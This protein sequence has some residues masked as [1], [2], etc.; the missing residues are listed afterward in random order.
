MKLLPRLA[1]VSLLGMLGTLPVF[2]AEPVRVLFIGNSLTERNDVPALVKAMAK[3]QGVDLQ[4]KSVT[5]P[6]YAIEDHWLERRQSLL[7]R[8]NYD[9]LVLQQGPSTR[10]E[11]QAHL[12]EWSIKWADAARANG[13]HPALYM[14]WPVSGQHEGFFLVAQSHRNAASASGSAVLPVGEVW[15]AVL[16]ADP[17]IQLYARDGFHASPA[18]SFLAAMVIGRGIFALDPARVPAAVHGVKVTDE[19]LAAFRTAVAALPAVTLKRQS[20]TP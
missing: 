8:G 6:D 20:A 16:L 19:T 15:H 9:V 7:E 12:R 17:S 10:P 5:R 18:G 4:V 1:L 2:G 3:A 14:V 11:S 13:T